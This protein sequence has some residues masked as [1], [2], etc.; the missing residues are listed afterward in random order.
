VSP[1]YWMALAVAVLLLVALATPLLDAIL[2]AA[3]P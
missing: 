2:G 1:P 3:S